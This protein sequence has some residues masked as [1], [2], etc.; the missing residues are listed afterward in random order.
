MFLEFYME[1]RSKG[2][3]DFKPGKNMTV[4]PNL[5]GNGQPIKEYPA[6]KL[7][8]TEW[9]L[10]IPSRWNRRK[11]DFRIMIIKVNNNLNNSLNFTGKSFKF[12]LITRKSDITFLLAFPASK[13]SC[14]HF[15][16]FMSKQTQALLAWRKTNL[17]GAV[18]NGVAGNTFQSL[19]N[20]STP[21]IAL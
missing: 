11:F 18:R 6:Q 2:P 15:S 10:H 14:F 17:K 7:F 13:Y 12:A 8:M 21:A 16:G 5:F 9:E 19:P 1:S 3:K 4:C 20:N